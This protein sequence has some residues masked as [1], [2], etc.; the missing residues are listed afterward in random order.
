MVA[1]ARTSSASQFS[2]TSTR[3][4]VKL[5]YLLLLP[6]MLWLVIF[7][8]APILSLVST[9]TKVPGAGIGEFVQQYRFANYVDAIAETYPQFFRSF[10]YATTATLLA[11]TFAYPLAYFIEIGR[12]HV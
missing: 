6:G 2:P 11:L 9:S 4:S 10:F 8:L 7:F 1:I 3:R 5:P 12:A